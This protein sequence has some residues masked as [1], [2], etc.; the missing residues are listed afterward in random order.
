MTV[1]KKLYM[2]NNTALESYCKW[3]NFYYYDITKK[4][5]EPGLIII[6]TYTLDIYH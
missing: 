4:D 5:F 1:T 6:Q 3:K 2:P